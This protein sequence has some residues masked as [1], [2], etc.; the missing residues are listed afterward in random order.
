MTLKTLAA[1]TAAPLLCLAV[2]LPL[3]AGTVQVSFDHPERFAD[4]GP[5]GETRELLQVIDRHLQALGAKGLPAG[6]TLQVM[7]TDIDLAG[8]IDPWLGRLSDVR[9]LGAWAE[10]V[11]SRSAGRAGAES[12]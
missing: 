1:L 5:P 9:V 11:D 6:Q 2:T 3:Q 12:G 8:T 4:I 7:I 10:L